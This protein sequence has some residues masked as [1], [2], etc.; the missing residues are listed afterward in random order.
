VRETR[1][2]SRGFLGRLLSPRILV[3]AIAS[4]AIIAALLSLVDLGKLATLLARLRPAYLAA[5]ILLILAYTAVQSLQWMFLLDHLGIVGPRR[6][7]LLAF[8]G[9]NLTKYLPGGSY[10][11]NYL[12]Y[13]TSGVD[14]ALSSVAT[15]LMVLLEPAVALLF[16]LMIGVDGWIWLRWLLAIGLPLAL[17]FAAGLYLFIESPNLPR[18]V[19]NRRLY[20]ALADEVVRF[21]DGLSRIAH[22]RILGTTVSLTA[23]FVLLEALALYMVARAL[24]IDGLSVTGALGAYYFSI[25]VALVIPIFTN[26]GTLEA[27]GV[28]A[29]IALRISSEGAVAIMV[30]DRALIIALAIVLVLIASVA[31]RDLLGRALR[32]A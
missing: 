32:A 15:T 24:H 1:R 19:T 12:L 10:F 14:P 2:R 17:L 6:D 30:L 5:A 4:I 29:L 9:A 25:G 27:G 28:A 8:V 16:L 31:F 26:L 7:E 3:S 13:E 21:R 11:Q 18:W 22:P 23:V 20:V